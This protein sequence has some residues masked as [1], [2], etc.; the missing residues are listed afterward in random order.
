MRVRLRQRIL[1]LSC[2]SRVI[3]VYLLR[4][5]NGIQFIYDFHIS[6]DILVDLSLLIT[7]RMLFYHLLYASI[8]Q[9]GHILFNRLDSIGA[10]V[11]GGA[12][13]SVLF[14]SISD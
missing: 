8:S 9:L 13:L 6:F 4:I 3:I 5:L 1:F 10:T 12:A 7:L 14:T 11:C 2:I